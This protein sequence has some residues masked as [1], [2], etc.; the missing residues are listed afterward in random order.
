[1]A[2]K[3]VCPADKRL[4]DISITPLGLD[5]LTEIEGSYPLFYDILFAKLDTQELDFLNAI[6]DKL[7]E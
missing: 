2:S 5:L 4:V 7:R 6:L 1:M 3:F